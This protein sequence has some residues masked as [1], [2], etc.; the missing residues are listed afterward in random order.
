MIYFA[1]FSLLISLYYKGRLDKSG[2]DGFTG[3]LSKWNRS[4]SWDNKYAFPL[5]PF[6]G[7]WYFGLIKP[8]YAERFPFS[9]TA[10]V[11]LTDYWHFMQFLY[12]NLLFMGYAVFISQSQ[13]VSPVLTFLCI[14]VGYAIMF[15]LGYEKK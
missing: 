4:N 2:A 5:A 1:F 12:L 13:G 6:R 10:L 15:N 3:K 8:R 9:T 7:W 14:K 11:F